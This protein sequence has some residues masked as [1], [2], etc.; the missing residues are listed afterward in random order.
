MFCLFA[1]WIS[2]QTISIKG[3]VEDSKHHSLP[4]ATV[5]LWIKDSPSTRVGNV[6]GNDGSFVVSKLYVGTYMM[7]VSFIGFNTISQTVK[8]TQNGQN[9]GTIILHDKSLALNEVT[10][11]GR[12]SRAIQIS[13]TMRYNADAFKT[14]QGADAETLISKMPGIIVDNQGNIQ[15]QGETVQNVLVDGKPFFNGDPTLALKNLPAD[16]VQN[17]EVFDKKSDQAEF[18]G[19]DDGN[20]I[21]TINVVT[22]HKMQ[23]G[24][25]GKIIDGIGEDQ[26]KDVDYQSSASINIFEGNRRI[27]LLG[28]SNN[29]NQQN[30]S[31]LDLAGVIGGS[32]GITK[33]NAGGFNYTDN[34]GSKITVTSGYFFNMTDNLTNKTEARTYFDAADIG[35]TYNEI[36]HSNSTN[37]NHR[38]NMKLDYKPDANNWLTFTPALSFQRNINDNTTFGQTFLD[39]TLNNQTS[40]ASN[41]ITDASSISLALLYRHRFTKPGRTFSV[42]VNYGSNTNNQNGYYDAHSFFNTAA[43]STITYQTLV[44]NS[45]GYSWGS[46]LIYTEPVS[47]NGMLQASYRVNY[48]HRNI[49]QRDYQYLTQQLDTSLS[50]VYNSNYLTQSGGLGYRYHNVGGLM[51]MANLNIQHATLKGDEMFPLPLNTHFEYSSV[52]PMVMINYKI[53][54]ISSLHF[55]LRSSTSAPSIQ[56]L[57]DVIN[58]TNPLMVSGGNPNLSQQTSNQALLRY[59][60]TPT[61]GQT[62]ILMFSAGK[63]TNYIGNSTFIASLDSI[64]PGGIILHKGAQYSSPVNLSGNWNCSSLVTYGFPIDFLKSNLNI[65]TNLTYNRLPAIYNGVPEITNN[66]IITPKAILGSNISDKVDFTFSYGAS[67]NMARNQMFSSKN[68]TY[69]NQ[70]AVCKFDWILWKGFTFQNVLTYEGNSGLANG[71]DQNYFLWNASV[72]KKILKNQRGEIKL[73]AY[74]ILHQNK[75]L[76]QN[77]YDTYYEDVSSNVMKPYMMVTFTYDLRNFKGEQYQKQQQMQHR[78]WDGAP[79]ERPQGMP[80]MGPGGGSMPSPPMD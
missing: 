29:I 74:D 8:I 40:N 63:T 33:T 80:S 69:L 79:G 20:S 19:F 32:G 21:K 71:Y 9:I 41:S 10:A 34:W 18:T 25:F 24:I 49:D 54:S 42:S 35:R 15:A 16:I 77:V 5:Y 27:T 56:Q 60:L 38:F 31:Q 70:T 30:F 67:F 3:H 36:D 59:T 50:N 7:Q 28:M 43:D 72:G 52:L 62:L 73:Q 64:L 47:K 1:G 45:T 78:H 39:G 65:S 48:N 17:I 22:R 23:I 2:A 37:Y 12:L 68:S 55:M 61:N 51:L 66:Y 46:S 44:N 11:I 58:N 57:E 26:S 13:D 53:S 14:I 76:S 75:S 4:G 6:T